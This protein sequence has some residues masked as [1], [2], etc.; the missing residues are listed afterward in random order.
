M[1]R[2]DIVAY[3]PV[4][5]QRP[6]NKQ[7]DNSCPYAIDGETTVLCNPFLDSE[8]ANTFPWQRIRTLELSDC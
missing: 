6:R 1:C 8:S 4:A 5:R 7:R 2:Y 3:R